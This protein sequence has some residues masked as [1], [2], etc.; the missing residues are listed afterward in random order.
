[1]QFK[2]NSSSCTKWENKLKFRTSA[3]IFLQSSFLF[4]HGR[5]SMKTYLILLHI[6][7]SLQKTMIR[8]SCCHLLLASTITFM[9]H[10][11]Y[12]GTI[13]IWQNVNIEFYYLTSTKSEICH[14]NANCSSFQSL[15]M[16]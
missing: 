10:S 6:F 16:L 11:L 13:Q 5:K 9:H 12:L 1:M 7:L 14:I 2:K 8:F 15:N 3:F 4:Q